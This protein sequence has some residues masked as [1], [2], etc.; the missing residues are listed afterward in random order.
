MCYLYGNSRFPLWN[1]ISMD[2]LWEKQAYTCLLP[3]L[4]VHCKACLNLQTDPVLATLDQQVIWNQQL[5]KWTKTSKE[6]SGFFYKILQDDE[7]N[8]FWRQELDFSTFPNLWRIIFRFAF[9]FSVTRLQFNACHIGSSLTL[10]LEMMIRPVS[11]FLAVLGCHCSR[12]EKRH[13]I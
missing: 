3:L 13:H 1:L 11:P 9:Q 10:T 4:C 8:S 2:I 7:N 6:Y 12:G 5:L